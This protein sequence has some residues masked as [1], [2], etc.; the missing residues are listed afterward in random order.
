MEHSSP[1][2]L[3]KYLHEHPK[4]DHSKHKVKTKETKGDAPKGE[5]GDGK[6]EGK[7]K[8]KDE[9]KPGGQKATK[10]ELNKLRDKQD[11]EGVNR[12]LARGGDASKISEKD[13]ERLLHTQGTDKKKPISKMKFNLNTDTSGN[14][15]MSCQSGD[16]VFEVEFKSGG[17]D[18]ADFAAH[19]TSQGAKHVHTDALEDARDKAQER[20]EKDRDKYRKEE[21]KSD[22]DRG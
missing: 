10:A 15:V 9:A 13:V 8:P 7:K 16:D 19:M 11:H 20:Y 3:E 12:A 21:A 5:K 18:M 4:A 22:R 1:E 17:P 2:A 6:D 14:G